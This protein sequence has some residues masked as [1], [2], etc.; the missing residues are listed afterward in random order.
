MIGFLGGRCGG[1]SAVELDAV[2]DDSEP[3]EQTFQQYLNGPLH[4][5]ECLHE[6]QEFRRHLGIH[7][8][9]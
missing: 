5:G 6:R 1:G 3:R 4:F 8:E 2:E 9:V 7:V